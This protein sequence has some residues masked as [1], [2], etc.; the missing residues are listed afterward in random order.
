MTNGPC[1]ALKLVVLKRITKRKQI[2]IVEHMKETRDID[3]TR[4]ES[5]VAA[6][7]ARCTKSVTGT[8][9]LDDIIRGKLQLRISK[10]LSAQVSDKKMPSTQTFTMN[11]GCDVA[12]DYGKSPC[13]P[14]P[15]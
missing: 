2:K 3:V 15:R 11:E 9:N 10:P 4:D 6:I 7:A 12:L 8:R 13:R 5:V 14:P 1:Y